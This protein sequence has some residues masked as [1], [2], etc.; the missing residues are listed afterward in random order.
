MYTNRGFGQG[1]GPS[2]NEAARLSMLQAEAEARFLAGL[3]FAWTYGVVDPATYM[4]APVPF[5]PFAPPA[6]PAPV[7]GNAPT[8]PAPQAS[9]PSSSAD[10]G[11]GT[12]TPAITLVPGSSG[13]V[14]FDVGAPGG[15]TYVPDSSGVAPV[16]T[17]R[18]WL[19]ALG[20]LAL[21]AG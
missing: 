4:Q 11:A 8:V 5:A 20:A 18:A 6:P 13:N 19:L 2:D 10:A 16:T 3:P 12:V 14:E 15:A 9:T 7:A 17:G 1:D 21:L